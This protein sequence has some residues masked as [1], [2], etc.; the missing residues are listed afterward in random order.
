MRGTVTSTSQKS[1]ATS[2]EGY[3]FQKENRLLDAAAFGRV[4]KKATRSRDKLFTVLYRDSDEGAPRLGMAISKKHCRKAT[5]RNRIKRIIRESFR[6]HQSQLTGLDIVVIN[7]P[8][9]ARA[10]NNAVRLSLY[11]HWQRCA[12]T[13]KQES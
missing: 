3:R 1:A 12:K 9:A 6:L 4:F 11:N 13:N 2:P 7:Q 10:D 8:A 5:A